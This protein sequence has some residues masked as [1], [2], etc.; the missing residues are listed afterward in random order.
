MSFGSNKSSSSSK[1]QT[2][3]Q[4]FNQWQGTMGA[5]ASVAPDMFTVTSPMDKPDANKYLDNNGNINEKQYDRAVNNYNQ[6]ANYQL[7]APKYEAPTAQSGL[8]E[9]A[10]SGLTNMQNPAYTSAG[11]YVKPSDYVAP[12]VYQPNTAGF[13]DPASQ[14]LKQAGAGNVSADLTRLSDGDYKRLEESIFGS[15]K[16]GL[17]QAVELRNQDINQEMSDR[18]LWSSGMP[19]QQQAKEF[20]DNFAPL[21]LKA[22]QDAAAQRYALESGDNQNINSANTQMGIARGQYGTQASIANANNDAGYKTAL[23]NSIN[24]YNQNQNNQLNQ[25]NL[26]AAGM[27]N[28][29]GLNSANAL[30]NYN[31]QNADSANR[32][33]LA[34]TGNDLSRF[35]SLAGLT[36]QEAAMQNQFN[37][38]NAGQTYQ[39]QWTPLEYLANLYGGTGGTNSSQSSGGFQLALK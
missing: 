8:N 4:R 23:M 21:Y 14:G 5:L 25:Y 9:T 15:A 26:A 20:R 12:G 13:I 35:S 30:N 27:A 6:T 28:D 1:V 18:G 7:N 10:M 29:Y 32:F 36:A 16:G 22:A 31:L 19:I 38:N 3:G 11:G 37:L 2:P 24:Q 33:N 39:S 34:N 17:D